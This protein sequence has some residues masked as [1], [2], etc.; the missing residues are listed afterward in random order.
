MFSD[1]IVE[2]EGGKQ[3]TNSNN[4]GPDKPHHHR[5]RSDLGESEKVKTQETISVVE[6]EGRREQAKET[7][8]DQHYGPKQAPSQVW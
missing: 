2:Q 8:K 5:R 6:K 7:I 4:M 3:T 1:T